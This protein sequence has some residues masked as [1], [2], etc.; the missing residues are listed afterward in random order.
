M[1]KWIYDSNQCRMIPKDTINT[2]I[3]I[4][5]TS[6]GIKILDTKYK[7]TFV[8]TNDDKIDI[9]SG[10]NRQSICTDY[11]RAKEIAA[12][13]QKRRPKSKFTNPE[14]LLKYKPELANE[15]FSA[16]DKA[17]LRCIL[18]EVSPNQVDMYVDSINEVGDYALGNKWSVGQTPGADASKHNL[19]GLTQALPS[20]ALSFL[21]CPGASLLRLMG[22]VRMRAEK[23]YV[24]SIF[25]P[26]RWAD[27]V[28]TE[29]QKN[30]AED[31]L[32]KKT[33]YYYS[34]LANGEI[35]RVV[36]SSVLEAKEMIMAIEHK[37]II[38]RYQNWNKELKLHTPDLDDSKQDKLDPSIINA[39]NIDNFI[40]WVIKFKNG[41]ACY[42]FGRPDA[43][44]KEEIK[45]SAI[46]S[47]E[48][49]VEYYKK[50][51]Y[52]DEDNNKIKTQSHNIL[53][54]ETITQLLKVPEIDDMIRID[55]PTAYKLITE[56]NY[57][58]FTEPV[59]SQLYWQE[60]GQ[61]SYKINVQFG[62]FTVPLATDKEYKALIDTLSNEQGGHGGFEIVTDNKIL[63]HFE[64]ISQPHW[65]KV[66]GPNKDWFIIVADKLEGAAADD[67]KSI[68]IKDAKDI[69]AAYEKAI[70][71]AINQCVKNKEISEK[72]KDQYTKLRQINSTYS[73]N[74]TLEDSDAIRGFNH[75]DNSI[76]DPEKIRQW[77]SAWPQNTTAVKLDRDTGR[78]LEQSIKYR[79][80]D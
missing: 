41:E 62:E 10:L 35:I 48:A 38:P 5:N 21:I 2:G 27:F 49:V 25:N 61:V 52:R 29:K 68:T 42:A 57:K 73:S 51:R 50:I 30:E 75:P 34:R 9:V 46:K 7:K 65:Y 67:Q 24:K 17:A 55:N 19:K 1:T 69:F 32:K 45:K 39:K 54:D 11:K 44:D 33:Q 31:T 59:T 64:S 37:D 4:S 20:A 47:R 58:M 78:S 56:S 22:A 12:E 76:T 28:A 16:A 74:I 8:L 13:I 80:I 71:E 14:V 43:S 23:R 18:E 36:G 72:T 77:Y 53:D 70:E 60:Q 66:I 26:N 63:N 79:E 40:M 15:G 3:I 6:K